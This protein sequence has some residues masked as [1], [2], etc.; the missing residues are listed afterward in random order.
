MTL[1]L[2]ELHVTELTLSILM[3]SSF[4]KT[5]VHQKNVQYRHH[6]PYESSPNKRRRNWKVSEMLIC[7]LKMA[8][9]HEYLIKTF[10]SYI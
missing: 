8:W 1:H 4:L 9:Q 3:S 5:Q 7:V 2:H 6:R 10:V